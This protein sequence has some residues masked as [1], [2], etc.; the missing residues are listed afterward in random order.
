MPVGQEDESGTTNGPDAAVKSSEA[1]SVGGK[2]KYRKDY[3][4][5][6]SR[7]NFD[8]FGFR[9]PVLFIGHLS[10]SSIF[11]I[12]KPWMEVVRNFEAPPIH[13]HIFGT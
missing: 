7:K 13:R 12:D 5:I 3:E 11:I 8:F 2:R 10:D 4:I 1:A 9:D 6:L